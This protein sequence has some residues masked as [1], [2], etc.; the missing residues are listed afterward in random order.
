ML[1]S[2]EFQK[3]QRGYKRISLNS[4]TD[5]TGTSFL[6]VLEEAGVEI[7]STNGFLCHH[8]LSSLK[9]LKKAQ[10]ELDTISKRSGRNTLKRKSST[11]FTPPQQKSYKVSSPRV[12]GGIAKVQVGTSN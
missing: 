8:C 1:C 3:A 9:K 10:D 4:S 12:S 5:D 6:S 2:T 7:N 11:P